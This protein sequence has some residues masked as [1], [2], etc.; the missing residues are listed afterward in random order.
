MNIE[1]EKILNTI[2]IIILILVVLHIIFANACPSYNNY[3]S[4][5]KPHLK[6]IVNYPT[7]NHHIGTEKFSNNKSIKE[8]NKSIKG[9][10]NPL[11]D[12]YNI[13]VLP[14]QIHPISEYIE[15]KPYVP[16]IKKAQIPT[17]KPLETNS[18]TNEPDENQNHNNI[19]DSLLASLYQSEQ[20]KHEILSPTDITNNSHLMAPADN[21]HVLMENINMLPHEISSQSNISIN[22]PTDNI[23]TNIPTNIPMNNI[24][25]EHNNILPHDNMLISHENVLMENDYTISDGNIPME[26]NLSHQNIPM[27]HDHT[28][29]TQ[30]DYNRYSSKNEIYVHTNVAP[31]DYLSR[32]AEI[33]QTDHLKSSKINEH[34]NKYIDDYTNLTCCNNILEHDKYIKHHLLEGTGPCESSK[35]LHQHQYTPAWK[36]EIKH[37]INHSSAESMPGTNFYDNSVGEYLRDTLIGSQHFCENNKNNQPLKWDYDIKKERDK[38]FGF[39]ECINQNSNPNNTAM[40]VQKL[41]N[42]NNNDVSISQLY[43]NAVKDVNLYEKQC[44]KTPIYD[45]L[46][47]SG[48]YVREGC[49]GNTY[50][51]DN[52]MYN[53][54]K[55]ING[56]QISENL[57]A[58]DPNNKNEAIY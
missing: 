15:P 49:V 53:N 3:I 50:L 45:N 16:I 5:C 48:V 47:K 39:N 32:H 24:P 11:E 31:M 6:K 9:E 25:L 21:S 57:Y 17:Y 10:Y 34:D 43:D 19:R 4:G 38:F 35:N 28:K 33:K 55:I 7:N 30:E 22:I 23:P 36:N 20:D 27:E 13:P 29:T 26:H 51:N 52:W 37:N 2:I 44:V 42:E 14:A 41:Y 40:K 1:Y 56:G 46:S 18:I 12:N 8:E 54:D 58:Y